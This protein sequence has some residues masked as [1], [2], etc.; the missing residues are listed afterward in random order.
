MAVNSGD[1]GFT[2]VDNVSSPKSRPLGL[3][4]NL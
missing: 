2:K 4:K 3:E 1:E